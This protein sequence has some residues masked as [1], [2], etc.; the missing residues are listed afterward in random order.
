M[1]FTGISSNS[2]RTLDFQSV[3][4]LAKNAH[5]D[6][7]EWEGDVH[8]PIGNVDVAEMI[9]RATT[10]E[11]LKVLSLG[12][13]FKPGDTPDAAKA[14]LPIIDSAKT[15]RAP[16]I[17]IWAGSNSSANSTP[18]YF[19]KV[20][21]DLRVICN[22]AWR[23]A[24]TVCFEYQRGTLADSTDSVFRLINEVA[25]DNLKT[26]WQPNYEKTFEEN[27]QELKLIL[28][29][30]QNVNVSNFMGASEELWLRYIDIANQNYKDKYFF[31]RFLLNDGVQKFNS[32]ATTLN[33]I[34]RR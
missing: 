7:I 22:L 29:Y 4:E 6:G 33:R 28:P 17:R 12:S 2:L 26:N 31:M 25:C 5:L 27:Q 24:K 32:D 1:L 14:F 16:V 20:T 21:F 18:D 3:I 30:L 19:Q 11:N 8:V 9:W 15:L 23:S 13:Y 10:K 34:V